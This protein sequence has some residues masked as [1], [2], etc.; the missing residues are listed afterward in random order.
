MGLE[1]FVITIFGTAF[2]TIS[3]MFLPAVIELAHP[4]DAGPR[5]ISDSMGVVDILPVVNIEG[6]IHSD[7]R[8]GLVL[9]MLPNME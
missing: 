1:T 5:L 3:L 7:V 6:S 8:L 9:K 4:K 2:V